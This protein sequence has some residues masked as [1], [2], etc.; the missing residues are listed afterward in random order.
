MDVCVEKQA[1]AGIQPTQSWFLQGGASRGC[2]GGVGRHG[3][4]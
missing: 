1:E 2:R 3:G 4:S